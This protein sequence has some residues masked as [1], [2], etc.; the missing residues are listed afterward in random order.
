MR[1]YENGFGFLGSSINPATPLLI[2]VGHLIF[3][4][5]MGTFYGP[6]GLERLH[7]RQFEPGESGKAYE[8]PDVIT[9]EDDPIDRVAV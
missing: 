7:A 2:I 3:G 1:I 9:P 8:D 5:T 4:M 6:I